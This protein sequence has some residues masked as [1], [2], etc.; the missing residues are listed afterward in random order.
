MLLWVAMALVAG[1]VTIALLAPLFRPAVANGGGAAAIY[2]DQLAEL[3]RDRAQGVI[4]EAEAAAARAE[5]ARRLI[6]ADQSEATASRG[7]ERPHRLAAAMVIAMPVVALAA[8]LA[9]GAPNL[10]DQPLASRAGLQSGR[11]IAS[12]VTAVEARLKTNPDD[13]RG[14]EVLAPVYQR[15][16]RFEDAAKAYGNAIRLLGSTA[17]REGDYAE[18]LVAAADGAVTPD[19][20]AAFGRAAKL[21]STDPRPKFYAALALTQDGRRDDAIA[22]WRQLLADAPADASWSDV[23]RRE[24]A[25]L[26]SPG[27]SDE[28][29]AAAGN[30]SDAERKAMIDGMVSALAARLEKDSDD[31]EG[32]A[33]LVRSYVVLGQNA[34]AR[35]ALARARTAFAGA[36]EKITIVEDAAREAGLAPTP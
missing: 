13:G 8:Y 17:Q 10:P 25:A 29:I 31:P 6:R 27:P 12:L 36:P 9:L 1:A 26:E 20:R 15:L 2:R 30:M 3:D 21:D 28:D 16:G 23:A 32:W 14:W 35:A 24:L 5:I 18:A 33:R 22:A 4:G 19:A 7:A 11:D 34:D